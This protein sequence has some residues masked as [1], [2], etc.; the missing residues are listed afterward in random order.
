MPL[1][2]RSALFS[3]LLAAGIPATAHEFWM[4]PAPFSPAVS[5][6]SLLTLH[7]GQ[8]F[9]GDLTGL[10]STHVAMLDR[11]SLSGRDDLRATALTPTVVGGVEIRPAQAGTHVVAMT[12]MPNFVTLSADRFHAYLH[13]EGLDHIIEKRKAAGTDTTPGR[14]R[15]IRNPKTMLRVG[16]KSDA[17]Y[18]VRTSQRLE[19]VPLENLL[20]KPRGS[21]LNFTLFFDKQPLAEVL[22]KA[23]HRHDKQ[24][25]IVKARTGADG[26]VAL[27][28]PHAGVWMMSAVHMLAVTDSA[29]V[30]WES[31]WGNLTFEMA[32]KG[33]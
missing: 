20:E 19:I 16:G 15:Y 22:V 14:E 28:L 18:A 29:D 8:D 25:T 31:Y 9:E 21:T 32:G 11:Y 10:S 27:T 5:G 23:W 30:D 26:K 24:V 2:F 13:D 3:L 17:T 1:R 7:V 4:L 12:S 33:K 6:K